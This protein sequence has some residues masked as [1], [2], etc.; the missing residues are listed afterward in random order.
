MALSKAILPK[1]KQR[2]TND[3]FQ[4]QSIQIVILFLFMSILINSKNILHD[5]VTFYTA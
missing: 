1:L 4:S 5:F 3:I 2:P